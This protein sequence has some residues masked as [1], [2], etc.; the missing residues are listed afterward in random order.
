MSN[1]YTKAKDAFLTKKID[2]LTDDI[3]V[4]L[5]DNDDYTVNLT[6]HEFLSDIPAAARVATSANLT[7]KTVSGG[8]VDADDVQFTTV[9]G[10]QSESLVIYQDTG[11]AATSRL[12]AYLNTGT[13]LPI[14]PVGGNIVV[15]WD[16]GTNKIFKL[17]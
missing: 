7:G 13:G 6:T 16:N 5:V 2:W 9:T 11:S 17:S 1:L 8:A 14:T 12:I 4:V 10:H 3:K 15:T